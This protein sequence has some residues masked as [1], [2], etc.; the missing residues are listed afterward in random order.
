MLGNFL[1]CPKVENLGRTSDGT[2]Y[3]LSAL[4]LVTLSPAVN[5]ARS[6]P[7]AAGRVAHIDR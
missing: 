3:T 2:F 1:A 6:T 5:E 4:R 7:A